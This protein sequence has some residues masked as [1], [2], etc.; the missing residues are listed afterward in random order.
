MEMNSSEVILYIFVYKDEATKT[1]RYAA[2]R[3]MGAR[4]NAI[5]TI[6]AHSGSA[7]PAHGN[8]AHKEQIKM[9]A[10]IR[11]SIN[12]ALIWLGRHVVVTWGQC[13]RLTYRRLSAHSRSKGTSGYLE[14]MYEAN[15]TSAFSTLKVQGYKW[16]PGDNV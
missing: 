6:A 8:T 1:E 15:V 3:D 14:T 2:V 5:I 7:G 10:M 4:R 9:P 12:C 16:L 11:K 13:L